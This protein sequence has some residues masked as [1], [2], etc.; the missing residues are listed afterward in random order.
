MSNTA[1]ETTRRFLSLDTVSSDILIVACLIGGSRAYTSLD[2]PGSDW[3]GAIV[4]P[5]K[6]D[7]NTLI[8]HRRHDLKNVLGISEEEYPDLTVPEP[9]SPIWQSIDAVRF[10]GYDTNGE[11]R[12][13][14]II[15]MEYFQTQNTSLNILSHKDKRV[16]NTSGPPRAVLLQQATQISNDMVILHGQLVFSGSSEECIHG[17]RVNQAG[18]GVTG[19][20]LATGRWVKGLEPYGREIQRYILSTYAS[21][22]GKLATPD[23]FFRSQRFSSEFMNY[24]SQELEIVHRQID[25]SQEQA[26]SRCD[27][28]FKPRS[29]LCGA[30]PASLAT[31]GSMLPQD[32]SAA[33]IVDPG[34]VS[35]FEAGLFTKVSHGKYQF[36]SNSSCFEALVKINKATEPVKVFCKRT[37]YYKEEADGARQVAL[38]YPH[39][40]IPQ[41]AASGELLYPFFEGS[42][43]ADLRLSY[44]RD[45][46]VSRE[47]FELLLHTEMTKAEYT[48][49]AYRM[50][51]GNPQKLARDPAELPI[52]RFFYSR[53]SNHSRFHELYGDVFRTDKYSIPMKTFLELDWEIN[54]VQYPSLTK[55]FQEAAKV[56]DP[57]SHYMQSCPRVFGLGDA[58]GGNIMISG[59]AS[60]NDNRRIMFI[61][62]EIAA[63][64]PV[65]LDLA[66]PLYNDVFF[67]TL[68]TDI[69]RDTSAIDYEIRDNKIIVALESPADELTTTI[70]AVKREYFLD[71]LQ[72]FMKN[73]GVN[74][75][76]YAP[77]LAKAL[78][79]CATLTRNFQNS[80]LGI[81]KG[82]ATGIVLSQAKTLEEIYGAIRRL[83]QAT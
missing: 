23:S 60:S 68:Y 78:F 42:T 36:S 67:N 64:H 18:F 24:M 9:T 70:M 82:F 26:S 14:K 59:Q 15:S 37:P 61:D 28:Y 35:R 73:S 45:N 11:K 22:T 55:L 19:D 41:V 43:Q 48:L 50:S 8:N 83:L 10:A 47:S 40:Q 27:C 16:F 31:T 54:G 56:V 20:L 71:P 63:F 75:N 13:A 58:H 4:V 57:S 33:S 29:Y 49:R 77:L 7:I 30:V 76:D 34:T 51:F 65:L 25:W 69:L 5:T 80:P 46:R 74:L 39:T 17:N 2:K 21:I 3:D 6:V 79:L 66:K 53:V 72:E 38:F 1:A 62:Y 81:M 32:G 44:I 52:N 12:A